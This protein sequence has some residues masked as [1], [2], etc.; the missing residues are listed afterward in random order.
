VR[1]LHGCPPDE[2]GPLAAHL[3]ALSG[4]VGLSAAGL[5]PSG[6]ALVAL[7][8]AARAGWP[9][10]PGAPAV[11]AMRIGVG[12]L[13]TGLAAATVIGALFRWG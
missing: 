3:L 12:E 2:R 9:L 4:A 6:V 10:R 11:P 7:L 1:R 8:L 13:V 5:M